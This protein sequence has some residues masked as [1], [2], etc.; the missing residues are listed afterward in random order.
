MQ[1]FCQ[2]GFQPQVDV[3]FN[4]WDMS[5]VFTPKSFTPEERKIS[6]MR[7]NGCGGKTFRE[8]PKFLKFVAFQMISSGT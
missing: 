1:N 5:L 2:E 7:G 4:I 8:M 6:G 3:P